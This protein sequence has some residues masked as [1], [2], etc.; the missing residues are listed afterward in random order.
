MAE[1]NELGRQGEEAAI[2]H[3]K[4]AGHT[5]LAQNYRYQKAEVDIISSYKRFTVF[6]EV[7]LRSSSAFGHPEEFVSRKKRALMKKAAEE[8]LFTHK[9][10]SQ[11]RFDIIAITATDKGFNIYHIEDAFFDEEGDDNRYN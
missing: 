6:T 1:H 10:D 5:I 3:L 11:I 4:K 8:Y 9:I 2:E 7:K